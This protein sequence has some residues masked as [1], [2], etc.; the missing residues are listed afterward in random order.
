MNIHDA[1]KVNDP[2][3]RSFNLIL[4]Y[5]N[6]R[7]SI[8]KFLIFFLLLIILFFPL[9][10]GEVVGNWIKDFLGTII[11]IIKTI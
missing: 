6:R 11:N 3:K 2:N 10:S 9:W 5:H 1:R 4:F 8:K 7:K